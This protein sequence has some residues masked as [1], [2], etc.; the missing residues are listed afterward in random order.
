MTA[1]AAVSHKRKTRAHSLLSGHSIQS[2]ALLCR[3]AGSCNHLLGLPPPAPAS[4]PSA[5][6]ALVGS[7]GCCGVWSGGPALQA[8]ARGSMAPGC[9]SAMLLLTASPSSSTRAGQYT[10]MN[11]AASRSA[12]T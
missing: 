10:A 9:P 3:A 4:R 6:A 5:V 7:S 8:A 12:V 2:G 11:V 1:T